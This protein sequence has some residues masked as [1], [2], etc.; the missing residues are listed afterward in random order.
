MYTGYFL[1]ILL[2][3]TLKIITTPSPDVKYFFFYLGGGSISGG[4]KNYCLPPN[5]L[6][7]IPTELVGGGRDYLPECF[8]A[9]QTEQNV[10]SDV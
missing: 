8:E 6:K 4:D 3:S 2:P 1:E 9:C 5:F 7:I 10:R